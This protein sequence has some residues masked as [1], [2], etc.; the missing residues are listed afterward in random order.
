MRVECNSSVLSN[1]VLSLSLTGESGRV[2]L[3]I[4]TKGLSK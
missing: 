3:S 2:S 1:V 4:A